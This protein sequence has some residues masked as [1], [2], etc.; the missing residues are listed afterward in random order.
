VTT[1]DLHPEERLDA[2]R[3]GALDA[4]GLEDLRAH[5]DRCPACRLTLALGDDLRVEGAVTAADGALL[6]NLV[7][8]AMASE[9]G[10]VTF[11]PRGSA[12]ARYGRRAA[13]ALVLLLVGGSAGAAIFS[14]GGKRWLGHFLPVVE[15][16]PR[17]PEPAKPAPVRTHASRPVV[18]VEPV[19]EPVLEPPPAAAPKPHARPRV[20][21]PAPETADDVFADANRA[22][23][24][25]DYRLALRRYADLRRQFPGSRQEMTARVIVGDLSLN[26][27]G[28]SPRDALASFDS[29][30]GASPD[31]TLAEE[32]R[33]GRA[34]AL[35]KLGRRAEER[36]AWRQLLRRHPDS[37][38]VARAK[39]RLAALAE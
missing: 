9:P 7:G 20:E 32:A 25:G 19:A 5:L 30:L 17:A 35:Q 26:G 15:P 6:A 1:I 11:E 27:D 3:R 2:A 4:Q 28:G 37:V 21:A 14:P 39:D 38:Q 29:Y 23:R 22:R 8:G 18:E 13:I 12:F 36:E 33:V 31:G 10:A 16:L 34:L 24:A